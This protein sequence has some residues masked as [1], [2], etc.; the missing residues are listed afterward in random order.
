V[1]LLDFAGIGGRR[2]TNL[3]LLRA[4]QHIVAATQHIVDFSSEPCL[5]SQQETEP[6][7]HISAAVRFIANSTYRTGIF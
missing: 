3:E 7:I 5:L 2:Q 1:K 6:A 4:A